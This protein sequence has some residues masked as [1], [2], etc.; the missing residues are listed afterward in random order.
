MVIR[1]VFNERTFCRKET[2]FF[3]VRASFWQVPKLKSNE[4]MDNSK[5][6]CTIL[7]IISRKKLYE[8]NKQNFLSNQLSINLIFACFQGNIDA[9]ITLSKFNWKV[10]LILFCYF[11]EPKIK[12]FL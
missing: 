9:I 1:N 4:Y 3:K 10:F 5:G 11:V 2:S 6:K 8:D 7:I 12:N